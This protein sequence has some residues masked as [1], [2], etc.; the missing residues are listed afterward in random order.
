[1]VNIG[2]KFGPMVKSTSLSLKSATP[3][4]AYQFTI[5]SR[6]LTDPRKRT[7]KIIV[8]KGENAGKQHFFPTMFSTLSKKYV[9]IFAT[10]NLWS[11]N[12]ASFDQSKILSFGNELTADGLKLCSLKNGIMN[13]NPKLI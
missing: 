5:Q 3:A 2:P 7:L 11:A 4:N 12:S 6:F 10:Y 8:E 9:L 1:M 13:T